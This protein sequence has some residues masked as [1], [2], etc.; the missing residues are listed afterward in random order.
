[1]SEATSQPSTQQTRVRLPADVVRPFEVFVNGVLQREGADYIVRDG[2]LLFER[3]MKEE[4]KLGLI[5]WASITLGIAGS[6]RQNDSVDIA[7]ERDEVSD[8]AEWDAF[9]AGWRSRLE[10]ATDPEAVAFAARRR[11]EYEDGY[12]DAIGFSWLV[13]AP[14]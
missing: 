2:N 5:R 1:M 14:R 10:V 4:G 6:Y 11:S 12:R 8:L 9:E 13:L 7:Y 3:P